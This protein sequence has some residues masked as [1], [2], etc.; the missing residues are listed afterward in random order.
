MEIAELAVGAP[1]VAQLLVERLR[2]ARIDI[3]GVRGAWDDIVALASPGMRTLLRTVSEL[4]RAAHA[5]CGALAF[6]DPPY[7]AG[8]PSDVNRAL[9]ALERNAIVQSPSPRRWELCDPIFAEW[10]R[11]LIAYP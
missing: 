7:S 1:W 9:R 4:H 6:G 10:L 5:V 2:S 3:R 8:T 11:R